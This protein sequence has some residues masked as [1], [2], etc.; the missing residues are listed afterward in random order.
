M[1][2]E[3]MDY[4]HMSLMDFT[5]T[6]IMPRVHVYIHTHTQ[7]HVHTHTHTHTQWSPQGPGLPVYIYSSCSGVLSIQKHPV[8]AVWVVN[9]V[10]SR[11]PLGRGATAVSTRWGDIITTGIH[12]YIV[13]TSTRKTEYFC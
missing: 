1:H 6:F 13:G 12:Y 11:E 5:T 2:K 8:R 10:A 4:R 7:A 9:E 3:T